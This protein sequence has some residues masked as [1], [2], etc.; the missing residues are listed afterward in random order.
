MMFLCVDIDLCVAHIDT[1]TSICVSIC[2]CLYRHTHTETC[3][4]VSI[5]YVSLEINDRLSPY[6]CPPPLFPSPFLSHSHSRF[7]SRP[8]ALSRARTLSLSPLS[9]S[10]SPSLLSRRWDA[11]YNNHLSLS[12]YVF[13]SLSLSLSLLL[14][15]PL[16]LPH[17][18]S[19]AFLSRR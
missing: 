8:L 6:V 10:L 12:N 16:T 13:L 2:V 5:Y 1:P 9:L 3:F 17:S 15:H 18:L 11:P 19:H 14:S 4:C 7:L